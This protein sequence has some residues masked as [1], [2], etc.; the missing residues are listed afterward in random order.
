MTDPQTPRP[1]SWAEFG[2]QLADAILPQREPRRADYALVPAPE[3]PAG[4][5]GLTPGAL[6]AGSTVVSAG[7]VLRSPE[8]AAE[9]SPWSPVDVVRD[10][11]ALEVIDSELRDDDLPVPAGGPLFHAR[12]PSLGR[13]LED[14]GVDVE[15]L[16]RTLMDRGLF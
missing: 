7:G 1:G 11:L 9:E 8:P 6:A 12:Y 15:A 10:A 2:Q 14:R 4:I 5:H 3:L 13:L 16:E